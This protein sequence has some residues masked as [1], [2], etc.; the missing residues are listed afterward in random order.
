MFG[1]QAV[2]CQES[3]VCT[4]NVLCVRFLL[5]DAILKM[6]NN[7]A[8]NVLGGKPG[9]EGGAVSG[10]TQSITLHTKC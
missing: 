4:V 2:L 7:I 9:L 5:L 6:V 8:A 10:G 3:R 1:P